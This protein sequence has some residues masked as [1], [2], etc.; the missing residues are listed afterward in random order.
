MGVS[1]TLGMVLILF[2]IVFARL[3]LLREHGSSTAVGA[4][5][6]SPAEPIVVYANPIDKYLAEHYPNARR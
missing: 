2:G 1:D 5:T 6:H 3:Y 4:E